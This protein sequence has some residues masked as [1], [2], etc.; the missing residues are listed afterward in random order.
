VLRYW[1][2]IV[3][4]RYKWQPS[5][6]S[7]CRANSPISSAIRMDTGP[8]VALTSVNPPVTSPSS[9]ICGGGIQMRGLTCLRLSDSRPVNSRLC[10]A[11]TL[12]PTV[13]QWVSTSWPYFEFCVCVT[14][15]RTWILGRNIR[16]NKVNKRKSFKTFHQLLFSRKI[17]TF[18][19]HFNVFYFSLFYI[20]DD[21]CFYPLLSLFK[22]ILH[23]RKYGKYLAIACL[24]WNDVFR[25]SI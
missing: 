24:T 17:L 8:N 1:D 14:V 6:W 13:Q 21:D 3:L 10:R 22:P 20:L 25:Y 7:T 4:C 19:T 23:C 15:C 5:P 12:L 18:Q 2:C 16:L 11:L 9:Q